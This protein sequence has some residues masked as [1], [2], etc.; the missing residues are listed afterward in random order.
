MKQNHP[1]LWQ[2]LAGFLRLC[3]QRFWQQALPSDVSL[4]SLLQQEAQSLLGNHTND[5]ISGN[6][7]GE[8][9]I[10]LDTN[11]PPK[12]QQPVAQLIND[13]ELSLADALLLTL[14]GEM[15]RSHVIA[16]VIGQLQAP[17]TSPQPSV[18]LCAALIDSVFGEDHFQMLSLPQHRLIHCGL[19]QLQGESPLPLQSLRMEPG[20]WSVLLSQAHS[21]P[22]CKSL[23]ARN[24]NMLPEAVQKQL[25][26]IV[27]LLKQDTA[28]G[29][30]LRGHPNSGR[31]LL[32][33]ELTHAMACSALW[34]PVPLWQ[35]QPVLALACRY[36]N[37]L[38]VLEPNLGPGEVWRPDPPAMPIPQ[39]ILLGSDGAVDSADFLELVMPLPDQQ[40]RHNI[41]AKQLKHQHAKKTGVKKLA[42]QCANSALLSGPTIANLAASAKLMAD[43]Q[44]QPIS[45]SH[46]TAA[47]QQ[48]GAERL[49]LLAQPELRQVDR[50]A[51][52]LPPLVNSEL[53]R[54]IDRAQQRESLWQGL[55]ATLQQTFTAGVR[56]LFIGESGTGKTLAASYIAT[57]LGAPLYRVDLSA[58][59]NKYIGESEKNLSAV[60][61]MAA[62][63]DVVLLFDEAD[64]LFGK[65]SE[66]KETGERFANML[67]HFLLTR[68]EQHPG[69]VILTSNNRER[70]DHAFTRRLDLIVEFPMPGFEQRLQ[71]WRSHLGARGPGDDVYQL[72]ASYCDFSGGQLRNVVLTAAVCA[73]QGPI[74]PQH[75]LQGLLA[76]Y[77]KLGRELP[78]KLNQLMQYQ[79]SQHTEEAL[80]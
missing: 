8:I 38:P 70:I 78:G 72:L 47:R 26:V 3:L 55:G 16:M 29:I 54:L 40:Q 59:M 2:T 19:I 75:L 50:D 25:P 48:L 11:W 51:I 46:I 37:W 17:S 5:D 74:S 18:H 35:Q 6:D 63:N 73:Q 13:F 80:A 9:K 14:L 20:Y 33:Q 44:Q 52:I 30:V 21:W 76:E 62:A 43:Q 53:E 65:R 23:P 45:L 39:I 69:I 49:R 79:A 58:V 61:D 41:W 31:R 77:R 27:Q 42:A 32:A 68:I 4:L 56:A 57:R 67:T 64:S 12:Q 36:A 1:Q 34:I 24:P 10:Q 15:E 28:K 71:L 60:L 22:Q 66:G 7:Y